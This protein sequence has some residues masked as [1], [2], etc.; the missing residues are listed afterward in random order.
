MQATGIQGEVRVFV[1]LGS[2]LQQPVQQLRR[3]LEALSH[4]P[5]TRLIS[6]SGLYHSAPMGPAGQPDYINAVAQLQ[7]RL[8][9]LGLLHALQAIEHAQGRVRD[10]QRWGA[11]TLDLDIL[12]YGTQ[13]LVTPELTVPH[14]GMHLRAFVLY[15][16]YELAP[17]LEIPGRGRLADLLQGCN[18]E[19]LEPLKEDV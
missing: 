13:I 10:G 2:N 8:P 3:A 15:P 6:H 11:R 5:E 9:P 16:L 12:L 18:K 19:G 1:G 17:E 14:A 4:V 7:T